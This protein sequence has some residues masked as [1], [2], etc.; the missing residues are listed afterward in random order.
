MTRGTMARSTKVME[1]GAA[2]EPCGISRPRL[3]HVTC[4]TR[5]EP[6]W[7]DYSEGKR[8]GLG[9]G[10]LISGSPTVATVDPNSKSAKVT[11]QTSGCSQGCGCASFCKA[12]ELS[13]HPN[14]RQIIKICIPMRQVAFKWEEGSSEKKMAL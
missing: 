2:A 1:P 4:T 5:K 8:Q 7:R 12:G 13:S 10:L 9:T 3:E 11:G 6:I 14:N